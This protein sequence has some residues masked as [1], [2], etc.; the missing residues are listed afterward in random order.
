ML[1][2][3]TLEWLERLAEDSA[4]ALEQSSL[5]GARKCLKAILARKK[6]ERGEEQRLLEGLALQGKEDTAVLEWGARL[7]RLFLVESVGLMG[8][9]LHQPLNI[10]PMVP[11]LAAL[12]LYMQFFTVL[13]HRLFAKELQVT[14]NCRLYEKVRVLTGRSHSFP[15]QPPTRP[16][17]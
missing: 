5:E 11:L 1:A 3:G 6:S 16:P 10:R 7:T 17:R 2:H 15:G 14:I 13:R 4:A 8:R 12:D 9:L